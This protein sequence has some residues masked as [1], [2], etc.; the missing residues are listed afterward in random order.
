VLG[1]DFRDLQA[2]LPSQKLKLAVNGAPGVR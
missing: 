2:L 1:R